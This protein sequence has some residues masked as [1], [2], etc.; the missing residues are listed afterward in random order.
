MH[1]AMKHKPGKVDALLRAYCKNKS[2]KYTPERRAILETVCSMHTHFEADELYRELRARN[3]RRIS[4][5]TVYR[6]LPLLEECGLIRKVIFVDKHTHYETVYD[7]LHHEHLIC[8]N[9][10]RIIEFYRK[11]LE[12]TLAAIARENKFTPVAHKLE[13]TGYCENCS[14]DER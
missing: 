12:D 9:C 1:T 7:H 4:R 13:I 14:K 3:N 6:T 8:L 2:L 11:T 5:A 10:G